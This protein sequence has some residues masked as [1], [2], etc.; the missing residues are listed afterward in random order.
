MVGRS[1]ISRDNIPG[2]GQNIAGQRTP[3]AVDAASAHRYHE[4]IDQVAIEIDVI[5]DV[6]RDN[7][8]VKVGGPFHDGLLLG[9]PGA[10]EIDLNIELVSIVDVRVAGGLSGE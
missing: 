9:G 4:V 8:A 3:T 6:G 10:A 5:S 7:L 1:V 2:L